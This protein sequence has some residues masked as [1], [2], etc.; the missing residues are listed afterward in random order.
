MKTGYTED[1]DT[2]R[3]ADVLRAAERVQRETPAPELGFWRG[4]VNGLLLTALVAVVV[5]FL[6][7]GIF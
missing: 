6:I 3:W 4:V 2:F 1:R 7:W 5:W